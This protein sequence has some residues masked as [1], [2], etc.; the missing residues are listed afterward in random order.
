MGMYSGSN[1]ICLSADCQTNSIIV[2][3]CIP[4]AWQGVTVDWAVIYPDGTNT[5]GTGQLPISVPFT[6]NGTHSFTVDDYGD[7]YTASIDVNCAGIFN[8][9]DSINDVTS[10]ILSLN[11][12]YED[13]ECINDKKASVEKI[14]LDRVNQ[15]L[16]L[17]QYD[18]ECGQGMINEYIN[19]INK[20]ANC[21]NCNEDFSITSIEGYGCTDPLAGNY[22]SLATIDD[23]TC[24][25]AQS[26]I[27]VA[28]PNRTPWN[29]ASQTETTI[30]DPLFELY[31][32]MMGMG[33]GIL[34][35]K[36]CTENI[37]QSFR[38]EC[39]DY[40]IN[41]ATGI[42]DMVNKPMRILKFDQ[43]N[44]SSIDISQNVD[45]INLTI[46]R[47][48]LSSLDISNNTSLTNVHL[49]SNNLTT[50]DTSNNVS[51]LVLNVVSNNSFN[52]LNLT[53]NINLTHLSISACNFT[54]LDVSMC[55]NLVRLYAHG[56]TNLA[57]L[58][59]GSNIDLSVLMAGTAPGRNWNGNFRIENAKS[60]LNIKVGTSARVSQATTL[61][62]NLLTDGTAPFGAFTGYTITT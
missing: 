57:T 60:N 25:Y 29:G 8:P 7:I 49:F 41:D 30:P 52:S 50:L 40:N 37:N 56:N 16:S 4:K 28:M 39:S 12:R 59:L 38:F 32:E 14:K 3:G 10:C 1:V 27:S 46:N 43:N 19:E 34:D 17:A 22:N 36:V 47:N 48:N 35:G 20:I 2:D 51:L 5:L 26:C 9:C 6:M 13:L 53:N 21:N 55:T 23:G 45:L 15:L 18:C 11:K 54:T 31:L 62:N 24:V 58:N 42:G 61:L 33:N 44:L